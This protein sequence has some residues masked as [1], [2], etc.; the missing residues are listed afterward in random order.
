MQ[1]MSGNVRKKSPVDKR[2]VSGLSPGR[3]ALLL[4]RCP[5]IERRLLVSTCRT[6][7]PN[8]QRAGRVGAHGGAAGRRRSRLGADRTVRPGDKRPSHPPM[9]RTCRIQNPDIPRAGRVGAPGGAAGRDR[10]RLGA[11]RTIR[12]G[13]KGLP[14][15][16]RH[17]RNVASTSP[18][19]HEQAKNP[20]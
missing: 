6:Q 2:F 18:Q 4:F 12:P 9:H 5:L 15:P 3:D 1:S 7:S 11:D 10:A 13:N 19:K 14:Y 16:P 8:I 20:M 17:R